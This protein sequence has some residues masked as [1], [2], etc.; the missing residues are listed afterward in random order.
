[1]QKLRQQ[2]KGQPVEVAPI[3]DATAAAPQAKN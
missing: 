1:M 2:E 3:A